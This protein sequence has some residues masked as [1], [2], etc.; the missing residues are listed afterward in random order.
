MVS[1][2]F[3]DTVQDAIDLP[4]QNSFLPLLGHGDLFKLAVT[5]DNG[6]IIT[7]GDSAAELLSVLGFK[8]L[9]GGNQNIG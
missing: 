8:V 6:I 2:S 4:P 7:G 9:L 1:F 5:N 3:P